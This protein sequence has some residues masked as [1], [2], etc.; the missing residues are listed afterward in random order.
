MTEQ[1]ANCRQNQGHLN[2]PEIENVLENSENYDS[3]LI[4]NLMTIISMVEQLS[5]GQSTLEKYLDSNFGS[6]NP[7]LHKENPTENY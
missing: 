4:F 7:K 5:T 3:E 6:F 2:W 1:I